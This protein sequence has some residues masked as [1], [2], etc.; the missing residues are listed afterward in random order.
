MKKRQQRGRAIWL[1]AMAITVLAGVAVPYGVLSD[2]PMIMAVP[3]FWLLFGVVV[4][5]LIVI[6][7]TRWSD[8]A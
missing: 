6:G 2:S 1:A 4:I 8:E 5:G 7:V 3:L